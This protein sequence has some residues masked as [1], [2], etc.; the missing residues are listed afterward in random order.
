MFKFTSIYDLYN[1]IKRTKGRLENTIDKEWER[2]NRK[3]IGAIRQ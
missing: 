2:M 1:L 3:T